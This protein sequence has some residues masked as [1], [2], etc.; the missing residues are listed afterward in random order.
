MGSRE[1]PDARPARESEGAAPRHA[2]LDLRAR[3]VLTP[4]GVGL[5]TL[6]VLCVA[7]WF[8]YRP[9]AASELPLAAVA[10]PQELSG[11]RIEPA[12]LTP[13]A[14]V[15]LRDRARLSSLR[16]VDRARGIA[17][18]PIEEAMKLTAAG[19]RAAPDP[20]A[21]PGARPEAPR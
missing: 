16:L 21:A 7:L 10:A 6:V 17:T 20:P 8:G 18:V 13:D 14:V 11:P 19:V 2:P 15:R 1:Q 9:F 12:P 4:V 5:A 3:D